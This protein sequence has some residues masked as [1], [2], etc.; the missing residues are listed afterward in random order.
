M[1]SFSYIKTI[2]TQQLCKPGLFPRF[3]PEWGQDMA[4]FVQPEKLLKSEQ[5][6]TGLKMFRLGITGNQY[7]LKWFVL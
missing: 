7:M 1:L 2:N 5:F 6:Q 3:L 4:G